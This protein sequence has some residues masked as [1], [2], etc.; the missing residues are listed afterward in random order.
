MTDIKRHMAKVEGPVVPFLIGMRIN[1]F[2]R[3]W[4]WLPAVLAMGRMLPE[5]MAQPE[6]GLLSARTYWSGRVIMLVQ[7]W[8]SFEHLER[9]A[10]AKDRQHLPAWVAFFER[11]R[12]G[13]RATGIFHET[14]Q[15]GPGTAESLYVGMPETFGLAGALG[16]IPVTSGRNAAR[17]RMEKPAVASENVA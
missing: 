11:A 7:Y 13:A 8:K 14:Y 2:W 5:L 6:L 12:K 3:V 17:Q 16:A 15:V 10:R 4:D 1:S 9:Y